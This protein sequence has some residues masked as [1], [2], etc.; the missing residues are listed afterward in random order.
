M[1]VINIG[2]INLDYV[3]KVPHLVSPGETLSASEMMVNLGGKGLNQSIAL[4]RAGQPSAHACLISNEHRDLILSKLHTEGIDTSNIKMIDAP[5]GHAIIQVDQKGENSIIL[6][7]GTNQMFS[8]E[9]I[10]SVLDGFEKGDVL[11]LQNEINEMPYIIDQAYNRGI[12]VLLNPSPVSESLLGYPLK[13]IKWI[14]LNEI[15]GHQITGKVG[16]ED[17]I[18][19]LLEQNEA[20]QIVLTLGS[21]GAIYA[22]SENQLFQQAM[23]TAVVDT[24]GAGDT[25]TGYFMAMILEGATIEKALLYASAAAS[26]TVSREGAVMAIPQRKEVNAKVQTGSDFILV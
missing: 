25:F 24:T 18:S 22:D 12:N 4:A 26:I 23:E 10:D 20:I 21:K 15:E 11:M 2:S 8:R 1:K 16:V 9:W 5:N 17:I 7:G 13:K 6:F 19:A 14:I 3:Y